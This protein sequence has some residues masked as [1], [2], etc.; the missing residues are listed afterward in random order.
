MYTQVYSSY[1]YNQLSKAYTPFLDY[2]FEK[3]VEN[4]LNNLQLSTNTLPS[5]TTLMAKNDQRFKGTANNPKFHKP[6]KTQQKVVLDDRFK[7]LFEFDK[8]SESKT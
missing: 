5:S 4:L 8:S 2:K 6:K 1:I 7:D 3:L